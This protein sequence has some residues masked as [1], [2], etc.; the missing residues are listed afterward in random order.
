MASNCINSKISFITSVIAHEV[1]DESAPLVVRLAE[2]YLNPGSVYWQVNQDKRIERVMHQ[3][4]AWVRALKVVSYALV[5]FPVIALCIRACARLWYGY[6]LPNSAEASA[7]AASFSYVPVEHKN[8]LL[9]NACRAFQDMNDRIAV[10]VDAFSSLPGAVTKVADK[11]NQAKYT[12]EIVD[13]QTTKYTCT[14]DA[15]PNITFSWSNQSCNSGYQS[16]DPNMMQ[17]AF[18]DVFVSARFDI[19]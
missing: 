2:R 1:Q 17:F 5:I 6:S 9:E 18:R 7:D 3:G 16:V 15:H 19:Y 12:R 10:V 8:P 14:L 4:N 11:P 13:D